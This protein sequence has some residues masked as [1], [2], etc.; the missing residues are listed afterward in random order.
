VYRYD[1]R[2][3]FRFHLRDL[4]GSSFD[5]ATRPSADPVWLPPV[6]AHPDPVHAGQTESSTT[7]LARPTT[8]RYPRPCHGS[9]VM[10]PTAA[11]YGSLRPQ[12]D[13]RASVG[14]G[15]A[16]ACG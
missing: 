9:A 8:S 12:P 10:P 14:C 5:A 3:R 1:A 4:C 2:S 11:T 13:E 7:P 16:G 15:A 6:R